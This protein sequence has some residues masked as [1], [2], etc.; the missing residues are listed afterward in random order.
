MSIIA[1]IALAGAAKYAEL[2]ACLHRRKISVA[3]YTIHYYEGGRGDPL[4]LLHGLADN[5]TSFAASAAGLTGRYRVILPDLVGHGANARDEHR[6]HSIRAQVAAMHG[7]FDALGLTRFHLGGNSMGGHISLAYAIHHP[8][9][10][11]R[12]ILVNAP[13][14][15]VDDHVVYTGFG[16]RM[17]GVADLEVVLDRVYYKRPAIPG[18]I[19]RHLIAQM[20]AEHDFTNGLVRAIKAG[21]DFAL[22]DRLADV[23]APTLVLWGQHDVVVPFRAAE[24]YAAGIAKAKLVL[25]P[26]GGHSPQLEVPDRVARE[27]DAF[28]SAAD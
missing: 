25:V 13:G 9:R 11:R 17:T 4:V 16:N 27:I 2:K 28:L 24:A 8:D 7:L 1:R 22:N 19:A 14:F 20:N 21:P 6:D 5:K 3:G 18:P 10:V 15:Q 26:D 23:R 12:L